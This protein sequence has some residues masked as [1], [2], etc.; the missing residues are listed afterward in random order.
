[1]AIKW[2]HTSVIWIICVFK[3][4]NAYILTTLSFLLYIF[5]QKLLSVIWLFGCQTGS[6]LAEVMHWAGGYEYR[7]FSTC[8]SFSFC[9]SY[10][11]LTWADWF[12]ITANC[13]VSDNRQV[14]CVCKPGY[15]GAQCNETHPCRVNICR[16]GGTCLLGLYSLTC[17]SVCLKLM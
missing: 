6:V 5:V 13:D 1:M 9:C 11:M 8:I 7:F 12:Y 14:T 4:N 17:Y 10:I 16:N 2:Q 15:R 3:W